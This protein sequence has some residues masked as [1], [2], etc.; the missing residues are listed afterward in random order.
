MLEDRKRLSPPTR[1]F[2]LAIAL[3]SSGCAA[4]IIGGAAGG[5]AS[6]VEQSESE[7]HGPLAYVGS[8]AASALYFPAKLL[9]AAGGAAISG[10]AYVVTLGSPSPSRSIW[11][12]SVNGDYVVTP[13]MIEG[14]DDV[15]FVGG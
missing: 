13:R 12:A 5:A 3:Q 9:F 14:R 4:L 8:V 10:I 2:L 6:S 15:D 7:S 11:N 1:V